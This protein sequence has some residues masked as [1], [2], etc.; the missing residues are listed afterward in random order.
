MIRNRMSEFS[1]EGPEPETPAR[2]DLYAVFTEADGTEREVRGFYAGNGVYKVRYLPQTAGPVRYTVRGIVSARGE[3]FCADSTERGIVR[4]KDTHFEDS[5][6]QCFLP[7]G[8]TV[9]ALFHQTDSLIA[10]TVDELRRSPFN[11]VRTC[12]FPKDYA[13]NHNEPA[14]YAFERDRDGHWDPARPC[15]AFWDHM[16]KIIAALGE[17]G[18]ETDLILFHPYDRWGFAFLTEEQN[19]LYLDYLLARLSAFPSVWWSLANEYDL[20][21]SK[22]EEDWYA[23]EERVALGDPYGHLLSNHNC[24]SYYDFH[25]KHVTHCSMQ[26][27][28]VEWARRYAEEYGKPV[29]FDECCYEGNLP[30]AWGNISGFEMTNRFYIACIGGAYATHGEVFLSDDEVLW[31]AKGGRLKGESPARIAYLRKILDRLPHPLEKWEE[32]RFA[33]MDPERVREIRNSPF[34]RRVSELNETQRAALI[35]KE[36]RYTARCGDR[37]FLEYFARHCCAEVD[38]RLPEDGAYDIYVIDAWEMTCA[39]TAEGVRGAVTLS[40]PGKEG[41]LAVAVRREE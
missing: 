36:T 27:T 39:R 19:F 4:A 35:V 37:F 2:A 22:T 16:E 11:K 38:W 8:T 15:Y 41:I 32:D 1:F 25:R 40:L 33:G 14:L 5:S 28:Q 30:L 26:T 18:I 21:P 31:W 7:F 12:V 3:E 23:I 24:F 9:Y 20:V 34:F 13:Y 17:A 6:G 29:V 10:E